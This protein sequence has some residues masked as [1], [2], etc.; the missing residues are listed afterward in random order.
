M[1]YQSN[2]EWYR[3]FTQALEVTG[4][5]IDDFKMKAMDDHNVDMSYVFKIAQEMIS[6]SLEASAISLKEIGG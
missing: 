1:D 3:L 5:N 6:N 2:K 4:D